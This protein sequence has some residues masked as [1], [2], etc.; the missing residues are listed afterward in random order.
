[1]RKNLIVLAIFA[2]S[3]LLFAAVAQAADVSV[4]LNYPSGAAEGTYFDVF[5]QIEAGD[6]V[7]VRFACA[8]QSET[9]VTGSIDPMFIVYGPDGGYVA[10]DNDSGVL[11][12]AGSHDAVASFT[13][14][15]SGIYRISAYDISACCTSFHAS[16]FSAPLLQPANGGSGILTISGSTVRG[17][18]TS[19]PLAADGRLNT[20]PWATAFAYCANGYVD[21]YH[22][23]DGQ[24][25][26]I[27]HELWDDIH[28]LGDVEENMLIASSP[29]GTISLYKLTSGELQLNAPMGGLDNAYVYRFTDC[30]QMGAGPRI[31]GPFNGLPLA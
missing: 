18:N 19:N 26:H 4:N 11:N 21:V 16:D 23:V 17:V 2:L 30:T 15:S 5:V 28:A 27:I 6:N 10:S 13:A 20:E 12:C 1:M 25:Q 22:L 31:E 9:D 24:G 7:S 3:S 29:D 8:M 14:L